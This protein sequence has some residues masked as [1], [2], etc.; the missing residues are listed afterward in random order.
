VIAYAGSMNFCLFIET[1]VYP[2]RT[3]KNTIVFAIISIFSKSPEL[4]NS[5]PE[6]SVI[7]GVARTS[8]PPRRGSDDSM[9]KSNACCRVWCMFVFDFPDHALI[10]IGSRSPMNIVGITLITSRT[11]YAA[12]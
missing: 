2:N 7:T 3:P 8:A 6:I 9:K 1:T 5:G 10:S 4:A 11:L 12:L